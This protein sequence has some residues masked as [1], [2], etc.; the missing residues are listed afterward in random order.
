M[1][2]RGRPRT[3]KRPGALSQASAAPARAPRT[4]A[5]V[6][7]GDT[8]PPA[9]RVLESWLKGR[10]PTTLAAYTRDLREFAKYL[11]VAWPVEAIGELLRSHARANELILDFVDYLQE[12][13]YATATI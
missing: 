5:L 9:Q 8:R 12:E 13:E 11:D 3:A 6:L 10:K 1:E 2:R 7:A 4:T